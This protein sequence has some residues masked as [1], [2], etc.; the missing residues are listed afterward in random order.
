M[1]RHDGIPRRRRS[2]GPRSR[3]SGSGASKYL[4]DAADGVKS[5]AGGTFESSEFDGGIFRAGYSGRRDALTW[6][7]EA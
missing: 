2:P 6:E 4:S 5:R 7:V 3:R 1:R